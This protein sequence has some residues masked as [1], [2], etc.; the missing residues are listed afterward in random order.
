MAYPSPR[1]VIGECA[2]H[3]RANDTCDGEES[4]K[5]TKEDRPVLETSDLK[6]KLSS[7]KSPPDESNKPQR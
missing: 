3:Q 4:T 1:N 5:S 2:T 6:H 7:A